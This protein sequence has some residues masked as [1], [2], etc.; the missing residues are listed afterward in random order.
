MEAIRSMSRKSE[1][2]FTLVETL[3][4]IAIVGALSGLSFPV[5][6]A[7]W[8]SGRS[9][10]SM[11][12]V[13][14]Q[15]LALLMYGASDDDRFPYATDDF[16][17]TFS[18]LHGDEASQVAM[19]P[20]YSDVLLPLTGSQEAFRCPLDTGTETMENGGFAYVR[21]PTLFKAVGSSYL[22]SVSAGL[23]LSGS[24]PY[25]SR[26]PLIRSAAGHWDSTLPAMGVGET[27]PASD[28]AK[29]AG[30]RYSIAFGDGHAQ[31]LS[32]QQWW[33]LGAPLP[34]P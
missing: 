8:R 6:A 11:S 28:P 33:D 9:A 10:E 26:F 18:W 29:A 22:Y 32:Y 34:N 2:A 31:T 3:C 7:A 17:R 15:G 30:Y 23:H 12:N 14:Q 13:R 25:L 20:L 16:S 21:R 5:F 4:V 1:S 24:Q 27:S 19:M